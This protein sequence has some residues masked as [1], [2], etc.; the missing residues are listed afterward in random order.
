MDQGL[1]MLNSDLQNEAG[2]TPPPATGQDVLLDGKPHELQ[3]KLLRAISA[4]K[5]DQNDPV[6]EVYNCTGMA[7]E[8]A[9]AA[10]DAARAVQDGVQ[11]I[12]DQIFDGAVRASNEV[13]GGLVQ[14]GK[15][16]AEAFTKAAADR[17][18]ALLAAVDA[19]QSSILAAATVGADKIKLA[20]VS[21][22]S[23]LDAA[24][25]AKTDEGVA[26]FAKAAAAAGKAAAESALWAQMARSAI[27]SVLSFCF[28]CAVGAGGLWGWLLINHEVMPQG[29]IAVS[30]PLRGPGTLV[31]IPNG[32][33]P[34]H[35][36]NGGLCVYYK[37]P[38]PDLP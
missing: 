22:T 15:I 14:G 7:A 11:R 19:Q 5:L 25:K 9:V 10:G 31:S 1:E 34:V 27:V 26:D 4:R 17:Q 30:D 2:E 3:V 33:T 38:L 35:D 24:V 8:A 36:C 6:L 12:S 29:V 28:A 18:A 16:F 21:L 23:S 13:K 32:G 37:A 20:A